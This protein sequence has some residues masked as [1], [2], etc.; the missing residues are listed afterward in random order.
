MQ[1]RALIVDTESETCDLIEKAPTSVGIDSLTLNRSSEAPEIL[2]EGKFAVAFFALRM[3]S[4]DGPAAHA[5]NARL[6]IQPH[7]AGGFDQRRSAADRRVA[8]I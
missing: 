3:T 5:A 8:G 2:R 7:D 6:H 4:P 1:K